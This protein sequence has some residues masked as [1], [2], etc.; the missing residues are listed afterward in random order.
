MPHHSDNWASVAM[1][2]SGCSCTFRSLRR[3][4]GDNRGYMSP[5]MH[6]TVESIKEKAILQWIVVD[7]LLFV[8]VVV[9]H[10][11]VLWL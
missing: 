9:V 11:S 7:K 2:S 5:H 10:C 8:V 4:G 6:M 3:G 1:S